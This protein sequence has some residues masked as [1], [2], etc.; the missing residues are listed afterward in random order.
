MP[1]KKSKMSAGK[2]IKEVALLRSLVL[3]ET[4]NKLFIVQVKHLMDI[5]GTFN[6]NTKTILYTSKFLGNDASRAEVIKESLDVLE[7]QNKGILE[8][9][10][11]FKIIC[12]TQQKTFCLLKPFRKKKNYT[13]VEN[14]LMCFL[15]QLEDLIDVINILKTDI[16]T[17]VDTSHLTKNDEVKGID[18]EIKREILE[19]NHK[20]FLES[21]GTLKLLIE[22]QRRELLHL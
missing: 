10:E 15:E 21:L 1:T 6:I 9:I 7:S 13:Q 4:N 5:S 22:K 11:N 12:E 2:E 3:L 17:H 8:S 14:Y 19:N 20:R 16:I 18:M